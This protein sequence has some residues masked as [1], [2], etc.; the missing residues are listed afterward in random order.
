LPLLDRL[1]VTLYAD[2]AGPI[3]HYARN[4]TDVKGSLHRVAVG[5][6]RCQV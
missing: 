6:W 4:R 2:G 3:R 1:D 5:P